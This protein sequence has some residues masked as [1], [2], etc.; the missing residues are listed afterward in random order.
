MSMRISLEFNDTELTTLLDAEWQGDVFVGRGSECNWLVPSED[1]AVGRKHVR[2]FKQGGG[3]YLEDLD[4][5][6]GCFLKGR[7]IRKKIR[8]KAGQK[9]TIGQSAIVV[10]S[11]EEAGKAS[12]TP[13][14][15]VK[16]GSRK[17]TRVAVGA[18]GVRIGS[19]PESELV[20]LDELV[21]SRLHAFIG[22]NR[23]GGS[24]WIEDMGS[25]NGTRVNGEI[26]QPK[27]KRP[28]KPGDLIQVAHVDI[29]YTD[30]AALNRQKR[31]YHTLAIAAVTLLAVIGIYNLYIRGLKDDAAKLIN[32]AKR[33]AA[34]EKFQVADQY[35]ADILL[36]PGYDRVRDDA[37]K[38]QASMAGW[39]STASRWRR[40]ESDLMR[41]ELWDGNGWR[42]SDAVRQLITDINHLCT[43]TARTDWEW[44]VSVTHVYVRHVQLAKQLIDGLFAISGLMRQSDAAADVERIGKAIT[45]VESAIQEARSLG[46]SEQGALLSGLCSASDRL[47][48]EAG[49]WAREI[50]TVDEMVR[51][52]GSE[53]P[54]PLQPLIAKLETL[55]SNETTTARVRIGTILPPL[56]ELDTAYQV[57]QERIA[58]VRLLRL[59]D[60]LAP[61]EL[62]SRELCARNKSISVLRD[63]LESAW[64][65]LQRQI[66][67]IQS[68]TEQ[69]NRS[70]Q[71][72]GG[73][74]AFMQ[75]CDIDSLL[76]TL[77][78][79]DCLKG[80]LPRRMRSEAASAYDRI[81]GV[82][83][84][85][86]TLRAGQRVPVDATW[87][88]E[89]Y[90][91]V[92]CFDVLDSAVRDVSSDDIK[93]LM[94]G[95]LA[96]QTAQWKRLAGLRDNMTD[97][98]VRLAPERQGRDALLSAGMLLV[99]SRSSESIQLEGVPVGQWSISRL[100][101]LRNELMELNKKYSVASAEKQIEIREEVLGIGLPGDPVV[102]AM[103]ARRPQ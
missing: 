18:K 20:L 63:R 10:R 48:T 46:L 13:F 9:I 58:A 88:P 4:S 56:R 54:P 39:R 80:A 77:Q 36:A 11:G 27:R 81:V 67:V 51:N 102:K 43:F 38:L 69:V 65:S 79:Y 44:D 78:T 50:E 23:S 74:D 60:A 57:I 73:A 52:V 37:E 49:K 72:F 61:V 28:L 62:P 15:E 33:A 66:G 42:T 40:V 90:Q 26:L 100:N 92:S 1:A 87:T 17:G 101:A 5:K 45:D 71:P 16:E 97:R 75:K 41:T 55:Q 68:S 59:Q 8:L 14:V 64:V 21:V 86:D 91:M 53:W 96:E 99:L 6:N 83:A 22:C 2:L 84:L 35:M 32:L 76:T 3:I 85:Y 31:V 12:F 82:E 29:L 89:L 24:C 34:E 47:V 93:W 70:L 98:L 95:R 103:W 94:S 19:D 7:R 30:G 25:T